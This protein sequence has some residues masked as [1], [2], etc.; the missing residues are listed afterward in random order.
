MLVYT[1]FPMR[2]FTLVVFFVALS[3]I[4]AAQTLPVITSIT[5][6]RQ[7]VPLGGTLNLTVSATGATSYQWR[8]NGVPIAGA[9]NSNLTVTVA[10]PLNSCTWYDVEITA[11]NGPVQVRGVNNG[12][13]EALVEIYEVF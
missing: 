4:G 12:T 11:A 7:V 13:G 6:P 9:E 3:V 8:R 1:M 2:I 10:E 5:S